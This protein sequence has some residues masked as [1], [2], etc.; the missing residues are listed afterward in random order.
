[1]Q[2]ILTQLNRVRG[3]GGSLLVSHDGL[4]LAGR[5]ETPSA[6]RQR[7]VHGLIE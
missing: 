4:P 6:N 2:E 3:V 7:R 1:M 5:H